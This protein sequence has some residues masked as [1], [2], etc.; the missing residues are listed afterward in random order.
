MITNSKIYIPLFYDLHMAEVNVKS[1][2]MAVMDRDCS[3]TSNETLRQEI[4]YKYNAGENIKEITKT[5]GVDE[6][7]INQILHEA[8]QAGRDINWRATIS[9][10]DIR[11]A[12]INLLSLDSFVRRDPNGEVYTKRKVKKDLADL[13][14]T[15]V[16]SIEKTI[17]D[18][19][20]LKQD[21]MDR[22]NSGKESVR[23]IE[24]SLG[25]SKYMV[26]KILHESEKAGRE[27]NWRGKSLYKPNIKSVALE[28]K[29]DENETAEKPKLSLVNDRTLKKGYGD[30]GKETEREVEQGKPIREKPYREF[31]VYY[32]RL[33]NKKQQQEEKYLEKLKRGV[34]VAAAA[35]LLTGSYALFQGISYFWNKN[36]EESPTLK[37]KV[38][39]DLEAKAFS[40]P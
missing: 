4:I 7:G 13:A 14:R 10:E 11:T 23:N 37:E 2:N 12:Y 34:A 33:K 5:S 27:I 3:G 26:Y 39:E 21:V 8:E 38:E 32:S 16:R 36:N 22:Y 1:T 30:A 35:V 28:N 17:Y 18:D 20:N 6:S 15:S 25:L 29:V 24:K 19:E 31:E 9:K 40:K